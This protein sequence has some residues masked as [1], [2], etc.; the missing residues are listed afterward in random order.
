MEEAER[1]ARLL[2][3]GTDLAWL[4][5]QHSTDRFKSAGGDRGWVAPRPGGPDERLLET[6]V[7]D[8]LDPVGV[9]DNYVVLKVLAREE[10]GLYDYDEVSG[11]VRSAVYSRKLRGAMEKFM[12]TLRSRSEIEINEEL[13]KSLQ[14]TGEE[15]RG[16]HPGPGASLLETGIGSQLRQQLRNDET[17]V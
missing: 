2:R 11:N 1:I 15:K 8:V 16:P 9:S 6:A 12:D 5:R 17:C 13:L 10:Q 14:I 4:A 3:Q 7:G